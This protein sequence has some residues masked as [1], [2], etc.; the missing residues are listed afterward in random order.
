MQVLGEKELLAVEGGID[1]TGTLINSI[2]T[3]VKTIASLGRSFGS[4]IRR[5]ADNKMCSV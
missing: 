5:L 2:S 4:A 1:I 3:I